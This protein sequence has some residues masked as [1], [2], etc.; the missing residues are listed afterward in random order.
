MHS[1]HLGVGQAQ[2]L[3]LTRNQNDLAFVITPWAGVR[4][5]LI[6]QAWGAPTDIAINGL[7]T[8]VSGFHSVEVFESDSL[9]GYSMQ[10]LTV[11]NPFQI[12]VQ[13][14]IAFEVRF[15]ERFHAGLEPFVNFGI[16]PLYEQEIVYTDRKIGVTDAQGLLSRGTNYGVRFSLRSALW[17]EHL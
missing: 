10:R 16:Q 1:F 8:T 13:L 17:Q 2:Y 3:S 7:D 12:Q 6:K 14:A 11:G 9:Q 4:G 15:L 5:G